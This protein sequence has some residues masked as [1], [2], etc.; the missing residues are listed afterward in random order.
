MNGW[1]SKQRSKRRPPL[2]PTT[3]RP[4]S[5]IDVSASR[6]NITQWWKEIV[7]ENRVWPKFEIGP[8]PKLQNSRYSRSHVGACQFWGIE[9]WSART[10]AAGDNRHYWLVECSQGRPQTAYDS[11]KGNIDPMPPDKYLWN[12]LSFDIRL[13]GDEMSSETLMMWKASLLLLWFL[14]TTMVR[15]RELYVLLGSC[16][17]HM[18]LCLLLEWKG[19]V[20]LKKCCWQ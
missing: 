7:M 1:T 12:P 15:T 9:L 20:C 8:R 17:S 13:R 11:L 3:S 2:S 19:S 10:L 16:T 5:S 6:S 14:E 4:K 18:R